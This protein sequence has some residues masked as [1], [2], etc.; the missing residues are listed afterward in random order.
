MAVRSVRILASGTFRPEEGE[1]SKR[2]YE[3][4]ASL[5]STDAAVVAGFFS[6][7]NTRWMQATRPRTKAT[8]PKETARL[9][10]SLMQTHLSPQAIAVGF[11]I[12][13][14]SGPFINIYGHD[15]QDA[16]ERI[17]GIRHPGRLS[18]RE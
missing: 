17:S 7:Q 1:P 13:A 11:F 9:T 15:K 8:V 6:A 4:L 3:T 5:S 12:L 2:L 18:L 16:R 14:L 10:L